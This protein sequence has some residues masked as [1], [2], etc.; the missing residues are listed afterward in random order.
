MKRDRDKGFYF[1][2]CKLEASI[3]L[4]FEWVGYLMPKDVLLPFHN[5]VACTERCVQ[6]TLVFRPYLL[7]TYLFVGHG[8]GVPKKR[9]QFLAPFINFF[10]FV[11]KI[12]LMW[13]GRWVGGSGGGAQVAPPLPPP[14]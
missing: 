6:R 5:I 9:P 13:V 3:A 8:E 12:F 4:C 1:E 2:K 10:F 7:R 11:R 14:L